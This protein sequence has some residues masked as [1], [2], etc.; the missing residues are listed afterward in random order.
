MN[1]NEHE[2]LVG[3]GGW[4]PISTWI[5]ETC[6]LLASFVYGYHLNKSIKNI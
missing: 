3:I 5:I 2:E 6:D 1:K 4:P